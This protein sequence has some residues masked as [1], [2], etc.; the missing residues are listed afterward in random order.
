ML[1]LSNKTSLQNFNPDPS[2]D[3]CWSTKRSR[4]C[5]SDCQSTSAQVQE[6]HSESEPEVE[7]FLEVWDELINSDVESDS[8]QNK[9][10]LL[11]Y[12]C[13]NINLLLCMHHNNA[14]NDYVCCSRWKY[15]CVYNNIILGI[16][17]VQFSASRKHYDDNSG[18]FNGMTDEHCLHNLNTEIPVLVGHYF[19][20]YHTK[21]GNK[22]VLIADP[23]HARR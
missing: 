8:D 23:A 14:H 16:H 20:K 11:H 13:D 17:S 22:A 2:I 10:T 21:A 5:G 19:G 15:M 9:I 7:D 12:T 6:Q 4:L 3:H 18:I 1:L